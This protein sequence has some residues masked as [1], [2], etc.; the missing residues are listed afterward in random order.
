MRVGS[1]LYVLAVLA[2]LGAA[3]SQTAA[4]PTATSTPRLAPT[5]TPTPVLSHTPTA[6]PEPDPGSPSVLNVTK[7]EDSSDGKCDSDCS[8]REAIETASSGDSIEVPVGVYTL[9]IGRE[10][11]VLATM[12]ITGAGA[13][14]TIIQAAPT[15]DA[16][17]HRVL[18]IVEAGKDVLISGVTVRHGNADLGGG[19]LN[20][21]T[22]TLTDSIVEANLAEWGGG[23]SNFGDL[24]MSGNTV[25]VNR[26]AVGGGIYNRGTFALE[27][28]LISGNSAVRKGGGIYNLGI[29]LIVTESIVREN[30]AKWGGGIWN[31]SR[32]TASTTT[33]TE[34]T[35]EWGG[36]V[37]NHHWGRLEFIDG[38]ISANTADIGGGI[39]NW[40]V[41]TLTDSTV[42]GNKTREEGGGIGNWGR[43]SLDNSAVRENVA[44]RDGGGIYNDDDGAVRLADSVVRGNSSGIGGPDC[45][46][47][48]I[49]IKGE[50]RNVLG[51]SRDCRLTVPNTDPVEMVES[52][53]QP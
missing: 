51:I 32:L 8:L 14:Q 10:L 41:L 1:V 30:H 31:F 23:I 15:L 47:V 48:L 42:G 20:F 49:F 11:I 6:T 13:R 9:T 5:P 37:A 43:L 25:S 35:A 46:G 3:C 2:G 53:A 40:G 19:I 45:F 7:T 28:S 39:I 12:T 16:A 24:S 22:L 36:G 33:V 34:N 50:R 27:N 4:V 52:Q 17:S 29:E 21:G 38:S 44:E 18:G 26:A